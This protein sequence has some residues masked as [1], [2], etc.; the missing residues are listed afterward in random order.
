MF[1]FHGSARTLHLS[2]A[3]VTLDELASEIEGRARGR[4]LY[5]GSCETLEIP[6]K[7]I[8]TFRRTTRAQAVVGYTKSVDFLEAAAFELLL[9]ECLS[10]FPDLPSRSKK[11]LWN[12]YPNLIQRLGV[13]F[14]HATRAKTT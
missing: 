2:G 1:A 8:E 11:Q 12:K 7:E 5:F 13:K 4:I 14:V 3:N 9:I 6:D 10:S